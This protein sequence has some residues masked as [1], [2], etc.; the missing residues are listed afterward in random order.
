MQNMVLNFLK[1]V[2]WDKKHGGFYNLVDRKGNVIKENGKIIKQAYGNAFAIYGLA[3]YYKAF[4]DTAALNLAVET[5]NWLEDHSYD[6]KY[7]GYYNFIS[8]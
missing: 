1:N 3:A 6:P 7:D 4:G 5:F 2:M 8:E